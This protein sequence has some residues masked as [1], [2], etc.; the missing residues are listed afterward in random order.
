M[1]EESIR[2]PLIVYDPRHNSNHCGRVRKEMTLNIDIAPTIMDLAGIEIPA[3]IQG[4][5]LLSL[6]QDGGDS[7]RDA[8]FYQHYAYGRD[9]NAR[10][11]IPQSEGI[12][13]DHW[14]YIRYAGKSPVYEQLFDLKNDPHETKNLV[15]LF[16]YQNIL[17][18]MRDRYVLLKKEATQ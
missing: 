7:W 8:W 11:Y 4:R 13:T 12:R 18:Q 17:E 6:L 14:K 2:T 1:Y 9:P 10:V 3:H 5:S 15:F 16:E